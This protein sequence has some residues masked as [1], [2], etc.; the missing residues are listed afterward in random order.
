MFPDKLT[1]EIVTPDRLVVTEGVD[2]VILPSV[3][4]YMGVR[5]GHAPLLARLSV[6]EISYRSG[7]TTRY[8]AVAGGFAEV[9]HDSVEILA[10]TCE[11]AEEIDLERAR[12]ARERATGRLKEDLS[13]TEFRRSEVS[14]KKALSRIQIHG[15]IQG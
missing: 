14:L 3:D 4:G 2:E 15:R 11:P 10:E 1:L 5:P 9:L 7:N 8:L 6:G 13:E 12:R